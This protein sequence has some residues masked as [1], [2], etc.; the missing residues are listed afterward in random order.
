M[1]QRHD[2]YADHEVHDLIELL[3]GDNHCPLCGK[4][5]SPDGIWLV[6]QHSRRWILTVQCNCCGTGS[7]IAVTVP[8]SAFPNVLDSAFISPVVELTPAEVMQ[9]AGSTSLNTD[10]VLDMHL[11]L[12]DYRGDFLGLR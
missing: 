8:H 9:F 11:F 3:A 4:A 2:G 5:Y 6:Q 7:L 1:D 12:Q 10:D